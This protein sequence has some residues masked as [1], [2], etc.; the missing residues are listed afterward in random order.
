MNFESILGIIDGR[1]NS[2]FICLR[3]GVTGEQFLKELKD[4]I[5]E[6]ED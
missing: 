5:P 6:L 2:V 3:E 1:D 4:R